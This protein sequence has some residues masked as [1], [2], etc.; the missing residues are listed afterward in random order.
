MCG[1][2]GILRFTP[3]G[4]AASAALARPL[5]LAI[6]DAWL[7]L[8]DHAIA[9]RG[10]DGRGRFRDRILRPDGSLVDLALVHR[11]LAIIDPA[12]GQQPMV[13]PGSSPGSSPAAPSPAPNLL[14]VAFNGCIYN[15]RALRAQLAA[16]GHRFRTDHSDTEVLLHGWRH[17]GEGLF[18]RLESMHAIALWDRAAA[19]LALSV[20]FAGEKPLY[21]DEGPHHVHFCSVPAGLARLQAAT[22][23]PPR[24]DTPSLQWPEFAVYGFS[25][26][27]KTALE[28]IRRLPPRTPHHWLARGAALVRQRDTAH[29]RALHGRF[30]GRPAT[31]LPLDRLDSLL[32]HAVRSRLDA[33]VPLGCFLSGGVDSSLVSLYAKRA[34]GDLATFCVRMPAAGFDESPHAAAVAAHLGTRHHTLDCHPTPATDLVSLIETLGLPFGDSSLLPALWVSRAAR[35]HVGVALTGDGGD[36]LFAGYDRYH[37]ARILAHAA[38]FLRFLPAPHA[39]NPRSRRARAARLINAARGGGYPDLLAIFPTEFQIPLFGRRTRS[40]RWEPGDEPVASAIQFDLVNYLPG[41]LLVK[42]DTAAMAVALETRAPLLD[43]A[44]MLAATSAPIADL[45][46]RGQRKGLLRAFARRHLPPA[47]VDRPK[48]GFA[49]PIGDWFRTDFGGMRTLLLDHLNSAE[50]FG[51]PSLGLD[52]NLQFVR[53]LADEHL[54]GTRDHAQRL[55]MLLVLSIW[56]RWMAAQH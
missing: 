47:L 37:A 14:A 54:A 56:S 33:D 18:D 36:E 52:L 30:A 41:D 24:P 11:R 46:P 1:I 43:R 23:Q 40:R 38:P 10:P 55:Y 48:Q 3:P 32:D 2:A 27:P 20:D 15:H 39:S 35:Q 50:P 12:G 5:R 44:L 13:D 21:I 8:L 9:H 4:D 6:P 49:I 16:A 53:R 45:M 28:R 22:G 19:R 34:Q 17:W 42:V 25:G 51:P 26:G 31:P 7:D 29:A